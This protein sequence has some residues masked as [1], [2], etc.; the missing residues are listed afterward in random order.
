MVFRSSLDVLVEHELRQTLVANPEA[1]PRFRVDLPD[2]YWD[3]KLTAADIFREIESRTS[4]SVS[5][6]EYFHQSV[7]K[8]I[9]LGDIEGL[10]DFA[11]DNARAL[12]E[13]KSERRAEEAS[14]VHLLRFSAHL[15]LA[16]RLLKLS[17]NRENLCDAILDSYIKRLIDKR[18]IE[19]V[20]FYTSKLPKNLQISTFAKLL[21]CIEDQDDRQM[22]IILAKNAD[23]DISSIATAVV[24]NVRSKPEEPTLTV[25]SDLVNATT[26]EDQKKINALDWLLFAEV[27]QW[28]EALRQANA[29]MRAFLLLRKVEAAKA[30][31]LKLPPTIIDSLFRQNRRQTGRS[32]LSANDDNAV[33]E[34]LCHKAY[35]EAN[36]AF[37]DW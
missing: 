26:A 5:P 7:Q 4:E 36:D 14:D 16:L 25:S 27:E 33:R 22:C 29:L 12:T 20:A 28:N 19:L 18:Q 17:Y 9:I 2:T 30:T 24:D 23:L 1:K 10:I 32:E 13:A 3:N 15:M 8:F 21:E 34:F 6:E 31:L 37:T 11:Y 35:L